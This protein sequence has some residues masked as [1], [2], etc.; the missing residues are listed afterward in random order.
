F[1]NLNPSKEY[2]CKVAYT[3]STGQIEVYLNDLSVLSWKDPTNFFGGDTLLPGQF[4]IEVERDGSPLATVSGGTE[5]YLD[6][7][8]IEGQD[9]SY[10]LYTK[11]LAT[12]STSEVITVNRV[13]GG[14]LIPSAPQ[15]LSVVQ[16]GSNLKLRW[17][18]PAINDDD[19]PMGDF[20]G[21]RLYENGN[22]AQTFTRS[23]ADTATADSVLI[24][25][26]VGTKRYNLTAIDNDSPTNESVF[27]NT[28]FSPLSIPFQDLFPVDSLNG[29]YWNNQGAVVDNT[30]QNPPTGPFS[31][32]LN[33]TNGG[34][35]VTLLPVDLSGAAGQGYL[36][37][38]WVQ[39]QGSQNAPESGDLFF[40]ECLNDQGDWIVVYQQ[41]GTGVIPFAQQSIALDSA[42]SGS[43]TLFHSGFRMRFRTSSSPSGEFDDWYV[44]NV[45]LGPSNNT[46]V[47]TVSPKQLGETLLVGGSGSTSFEISNT[48]ALPSSLNYSVSGAS[49]VSWL[50]AA[51]ESG[52]LS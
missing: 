16:D 10:N 41:A 25:E 45:F 39:P 48:N 19:T 35:E 38:F 20:A 27:G 22:L 49:A 6:N 11:V 9:Y 30:S 46:P 17:V 37:V 24:P 1:I 13:A 14:S 51:P 44:D 32:R 26:P 40:A 3:P 15:S 52:V 5:I 31:L 12:D 50:S 8:L 18:N 23:S 28:A 34:D 33:G 29:N 21:V 42:P 36:L 7:G 47:M 43:G 2:D 4:T